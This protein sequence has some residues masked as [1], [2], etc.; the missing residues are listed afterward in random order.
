MPGRRRARSSPLIRRVGRL[1]RLLGNS[2][3]YVQAD[4][5]GPIIESEAIAH[6]SVRIFV[7]LTDGRIEGGFHTSGS[8]FGG[9]KS[10][11]M[12]GTRLTMHKLEG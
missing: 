4:L 5:D 6:E 3:Y 2:R 12:T 10:M 8:K 7:D 9:K 1:L 11:K